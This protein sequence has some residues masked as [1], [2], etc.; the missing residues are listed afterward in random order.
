MELKITTTGNK[1]AAQKF[2]K[3]AREQMRE[4]KRSMKL[5]KL[6]QNK[7]EKRPY[8]GV[9]ISCHSWTG[10]DAVNIHVEPVG[11]VKQPVQRK[12]QILEDFYWY[13]FNSSTLD[14][15][16]LLGTN[17]LEDIQTDSLGNT[18]VVGQAKT[19]TTPASGEPSIIKYD[20][21]G[22]LM[23]RK[24]INASDEFDIAQAVELDALTGD[25]YVTY[26]KLNA[27][28]LNC[29][30]C[31]VAKY[32]RTGV[33]QWQKRLTLSS[34]EDVDVFGW[35]DAI[36]LDTSDPTNNQYTIVGRLYHW[37]CFLYRAFI[38]RYN[39]DGSLAW[40]K[41]A[42]VY[43]DGEQVPG[44]GGWSEDPPLGG[45]YATVE[46]RPHFEAAVT[47]PSGNT[48]VVGHHF[49]GIFIYPAGLIVKFSPSG[50][51]TWKRSVYGETVQ[52]DEL[53][54]WYDDG[55]KITDACCDAAGNLY[56]I[57]HAHIWEVDL[58]HFNIFKFD[59]DGD[60][61]WHR[62]VE[63]MSPGEWNPQ[64]PIAFSGE[65][66]VWGSQLYVL[67]PRY[68][69]GG[70]QMG[71]VLAQMDTVTG[72]PAWQRVL[73]IPPFLLGSETISGVFPR[74]LEVRDGDLHIAASIDLEEFSVTMK[75]PGTATPVGQHARLNV[76]AST[77]VFYS[78]M[79]DV[80]YREEEAGEGHYSMYV[81][82]E[83][84]LTIATGDFI[85][86]SLSDGE[87]VTENWGVTD[88]IL[89]RRREM[90]VL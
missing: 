30:D 10:N 89:V 73:S 64:N 15:A 79:A 1:F 70:D 35:G 42:G 47:D 5:S 80:P 13:A 44:D 57:A 84:D 82:S 78:D 34:D 25:F 17:S 7:L 51:V 22:R 27:S 88:R 55:V 11:G 68:P 14:G 71:M 69:N 9:V 21:D 72:D 3:E 36:K 32:D 85:A 28:R 38:A 90:E 67:F 8:P 20:Q 49:P 43:V 86:S 66:A 16:I 54:N 39:A 4:L 58:C 75:L 76:A 60:L 50:T 2:Y 53:V 52:N 61:L 26:S 48:Y 59:S 65:I 18:Y 6:Q 83:F 74:G 63:V 46:E 12:F 33:L 31:C 56:V 87:R 19:G 29:Y 24:L 62:I 41:T 40:Q 37:K 81:T 45:T 77:F 23:W